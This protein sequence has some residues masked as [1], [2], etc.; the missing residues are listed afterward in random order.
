MNNQERIAQ[1]NS[2]ADH[3]GKASVEAMVTG[4]TEL[5]ARVAKGEGSEKPMHLDRVMQSHTLERFISRIKTMVSLLPNME[6]KKNS[7]VLIVNRHPGEGEDKISKEVSRA[8]ARAL[9]TNCK[10]SWRR[11]E[12]YG[13]YPQ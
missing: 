9:T 10:M 7:Y 3:L 12:G 2:L 5:M 13:G 11:L 1:E 4:V 6:F 8:L